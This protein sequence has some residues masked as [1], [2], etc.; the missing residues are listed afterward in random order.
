MSDYGCSESP[1]TLSDSWTQQPLTYP[2]IR[3]LHLTEAQSQQTERM[4]TTAAGAQK[5]GYPAGTKEEKTSIL[6]LRV[7]YRCCKAKSDSSW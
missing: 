5:C 6:D 4:F 3:T 2:K 7:P 1:D